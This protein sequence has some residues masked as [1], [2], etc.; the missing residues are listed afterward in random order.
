MRIIL[1]SKS[2][3]RSELLKSIGLDFEVLAD[4]SVD[5]Q[6]MLDGTAAQLEHR[7][8][9]LALAKGRE[10]SRQHGEAIV[11]SADTVVVLGDLVLGKPAG[12][13]D[14]TRMLGLLSGRTHRVMTAVAV[15]RTASGRSMTATATTEVTFRELSEASIAAY[16]RREH[17]QDKA[18]A[19]AIQGMG[20]LLVD[21]IR[22]E[23]TT[24]VGLPLG[25]TCKLLKEF[26]VSLL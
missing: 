14:A 19:Y 8:E 15:Q 18:G 4:G 25:T 11:I 22:G 3:R 5:E 10:V 16:V 23:Y 21:R 12:E 24:V 13:R 1:A 9:Q 6:A 20:A 2:P 26:G 17:T 7:L